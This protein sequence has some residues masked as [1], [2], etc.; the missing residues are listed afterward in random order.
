MSGWD[1][2]GAAAGAAGGGSPFRNRQGDGLDD[3]DDDEFGPGVGGGRSGGDGRGLSRILERILGTPEKFSG[4]DEDWEGFR[5]GLINKVQATDE[6]L[7]LAMER[8]EMGTV[9]V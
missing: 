3:D 7:G 5:S 8:I 6:Q 9:P 2:V 4:K 1:G